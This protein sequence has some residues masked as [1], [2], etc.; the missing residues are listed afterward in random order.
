MIKCIAAYAQAQGFQR[1]YLGRSDIAQTYV[2][3]DQFD[4]P[5]L[6][7]FLRRFSYD[8]FFGYLR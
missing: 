6:L 5:N 4:K 7:C 3:P 2:G 1:D 8:G